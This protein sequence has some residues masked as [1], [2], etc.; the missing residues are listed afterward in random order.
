MTLSIGGVTIPDGEKP[1]DVQLNYSGPVIWDEKNPLN[2]K[3]RILRKVGQ[4]APS[5]TLHMYL[6]SATRISLQ[7]LVDTGTEQNIPFVWDDG[8]LDIDQVVTM[9]FSARQN[10]LQVAVARWDCEAV[11]VVET[12]NNL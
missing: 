2:Y 11:L 7:N 9:K 4:D 1:Y 12:D 8:P 10:A 6:T 3:G 5:H